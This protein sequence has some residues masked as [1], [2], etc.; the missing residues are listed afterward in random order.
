LLVLR[1]RADFA[2]DEERDDDEGSDD[3]SWSPENDEDDELT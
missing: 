3:G 2:S 1:E